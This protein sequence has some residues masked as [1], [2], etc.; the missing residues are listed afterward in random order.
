[1]VSHQP[2]GIPLAKQAE[3]IG[4]DPDGERIV[5]RAAIRAEWKPIEVTEKLSYVKS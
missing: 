4:N 3:V 1:M 5:G 2:D